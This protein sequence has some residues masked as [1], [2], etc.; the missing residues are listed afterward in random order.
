MNHTT[1]AQ[2]HNA[3][4][5][6]IWERAKQLKTET[7]FNASSRHSP[8]PWTALSGESV[9]IGIPGQGALAT[10]GEQ[11]RQGGL[12]LSREI[13]EANAALIVRAVNHAGKLAEALRDLSRLVHQNNAL[14]HAGLGV[15]PEAWSEMYQAT[16][17]ARAALAAY[18]AAQ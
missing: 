9:T 7:R 2:R 18:E 10:M 5:D 11:D 4:Q 6:K 12:H 3:R 14:Q 15:S 16:N 8:L 13:A 1:A 17:D